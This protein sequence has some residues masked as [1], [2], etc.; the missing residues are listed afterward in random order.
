MPGGNSA[1]PFNWLFFGDPE[2]RGQGVRASARRPRFGV[3]KSSIS[4]GATLYYPS[5]LNL[6]S[7]VELGIPAVECSA[8]LVL[9]SFTG[10]YS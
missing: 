4:F 3:A 6:R 1:V 9:F 2:K 5:S 8:H 7:G 10:F